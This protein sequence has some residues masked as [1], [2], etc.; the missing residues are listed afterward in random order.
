[1]KKPDRIQLARE[2]IARV[3]KEMQ[4][5]RLTESVCNSM[6]GRIAPYS[7]EPAIKLEKV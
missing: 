1:V 7:S 2:I 6:R 4:K 5:P 3:K